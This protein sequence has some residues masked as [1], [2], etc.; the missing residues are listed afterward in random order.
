[1]INQTEF[2]CLFLIYKVGLVVGVEELR[3]GGV[4]RRER[5]QSPPH[6]IVILTIL[7]YAI[8]IKQNLFGTI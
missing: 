8:K 6:P 5:V 7:T 2:V 1:M 4:I 3:S